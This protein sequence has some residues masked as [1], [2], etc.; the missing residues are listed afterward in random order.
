MNNTTGT[1]ML[2]A[3]IPAYNEEAYIGDVL[4]VLTAVSE[5]A[6][7]LVVDDGSSD[8][9]PAV[10][11][12]HSQQDSR[13]TLLTLSQNGGKGGAILAGARAAETDLLIFL[14]ADLRGLQP[15]HIRALLQPVL[16]QRC[17]MTL[18]LFEGG[19]RHTDWAHRLFPFLSGQR[20]LRWSRF[21]HTPG[22]QDARWGVE[23]ALSLHAW[24]Q[25]YQVG[26][27]PWHGVTHVTGGEKE[28]DGRFW[29]WSEI[30]MW[31]DIGHYLL[32]HAWQK[33]HPRLG[34][35]P[36]PASQ[37]KFPLERII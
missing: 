35:K 20:C 27:V 14:D 15:Q 4:Q 24:R 3:I 19:R 36:R 11:Q 2:T 28:P 26:R 13:V 30:S 21:C 34:E 16:S 8:G 17:T 5:L 31:L 7:I 33:P 25:G 1:E 23:T 10:V 37:S 32:H 9:T 22:L 6:R 29:V 12:A 18:G